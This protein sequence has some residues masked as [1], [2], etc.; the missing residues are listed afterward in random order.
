MHLNSY[1]QI[2]LDKDNV[3]TIVWFISI[4]QNK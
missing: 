1:K 2:L 3:I 4:L